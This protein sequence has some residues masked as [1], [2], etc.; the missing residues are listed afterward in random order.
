VIES[1]PPS[2]E[3]PRALSRPTLAVALACLLL[4][5]ALSLW[6][7]LTA[8]M[9]DATSLHARSIVTEWRAGAGPVATPAVWDSTHRQL[10]S[11]LQ[12]APGNAQLHDD[13]GYLHASRAMAMGA[14][15]MDTPEYAQQQDLLDLAIA[16]YRA[17]CALRPTF[18]FTWVHL[19]LAKHFRGQHDAEFLNAFERGLQYG[20]SESD[21]QATLGQIAIANWARLSPPSQLAVARMADKAKR[22]SRIMIQV[23]AERAGIVL[24][25]P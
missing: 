23:M 5:G 7:V 8:A 3:P 16:H 24:P 19:A 21:L 18:P 6:F 25:A 4:V 1:A 20:H 22:S 11:A 10:D 15:P 12:T 13:L 14:V 2:T 17:A 9:A